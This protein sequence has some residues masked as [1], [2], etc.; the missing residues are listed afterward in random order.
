MARILALDD[1]AL[2]RRA[3]DRILRRKGHEVI[4]AAAAGQALRLAH[5]VD[6]DIALVDHQLPDASGI[7]VLSKLRALQPRCIRMLITGRLDLPMVKEAVNQG[8]VSKVIE[9]PIDQVTLVEAVDG[10]LRYMQRMQDVVESQH[11]ALREAEGEALEECLSGDDIQLALQPLLNRDGAVYAHEALLRSSHQTLHGPMPVLRAAEEHGRL[12]DLGHVIVNRAVEWMRIL[13]EERMLFLNLH[14]DELSDPEGMAERLTPLSPWA[15]RI[16]LEI[17]ERRQLSGVE[18][19]ER[20]VELA[21]E[22]G[23]GIAVDDLGAGYSSL[24]VLAELRPSVIKVDMSIV[25]GVDADERKQ[26]LIELIVS[27]AKATEALV[28]G[29]GVET[30]GEANCLH[31]IGIDLFQGYFYGK[32]TLDKAEALRGTRPRPEGG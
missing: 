16:V 13:P 5:D 28:V 10:S 17:T 12:P 6:F 24:A 26:R 1:D 30:E 25:R 19:W 3:I 20:S 9:K 14:P 15:E 23:F 22:M 7:E 29:E 27:F 8:E 4:Q 32:P 21:T 31:A 18:H 2:V 11:M